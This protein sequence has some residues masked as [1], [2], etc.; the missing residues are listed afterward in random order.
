M[1]G[2]LCWV[3]LNF[4]AKNI[5]YV[6]QQNSNLLTRFFKRVSPESDQRTVLL[7]V[8]PNGEL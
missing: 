2:N 1:I 8:L 3:I 6:R 4:H 7:S 5:D